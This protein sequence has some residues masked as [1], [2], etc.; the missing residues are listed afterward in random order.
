MKYSKLLTKLLLVCFVCFSAASCDLFEQ[1]SRKYDGDDKVEFFPPEATVAEGSGQF[2]A[3]VQLISKKGQ[4]NSAK[5]IEFTVVDSMTTADPANYDILTPSP[6]TLAA[7]SSQTLVSLDIL[8]GPV[9][10][11]NQ[12]TLTLALEGSSDGSVGTGPNIRFLEMIIVGQ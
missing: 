3:Q 2:D 6:V 1:E 9:A 5:D 4:L 11:G 10:P 12:V 7:D 8:N